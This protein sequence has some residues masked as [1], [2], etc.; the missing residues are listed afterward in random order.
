MSRAASTF[1]QT[2][3]KRAMAAAEAAGKTVASIEVKS[4][5]TIIIHLATQTRKASPQ[6]VLVF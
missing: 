4:D 6:P 3:V 1:K 5:G 2:D